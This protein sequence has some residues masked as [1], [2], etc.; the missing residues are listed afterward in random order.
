MEFLKCKACFS[1]LTDYKINLQYTMQSYCF[2]DKAN[3][4]FTYL[5]FTFNRR[6][7]HVRTTVFTL[8]SGCIDNRT[9]YY[10]IFAYGKC[11]F[12]FNSEV[13]VCPKK[14]YFA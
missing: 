9:A 2:F 12:L 13:S 4:R 8:V 14:E 10:L 11:P 5:G 1:T 6:L 3:I 7:W